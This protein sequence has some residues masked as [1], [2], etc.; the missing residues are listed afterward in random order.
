MS[1]ADTGEVTFTISAVDNASDTIQEVQSGL[2]DLTDAANSAGPAMSDVASSTGDATASMGGLN[3]STMWSMQGFMGLSSTVRLGIRDFEQMELMHIRIETASLAVTKA[4]E[5]Y[6]AAVQKYGENSQQAVDAQQKLTDATDRLNYYQ[7]RNMLNYV[8]MGLQIPMIIASITQMCAGLGGLGAALGGAG[9]AVA[10]VVAALGPVGIA[11]IAIVAAIAILYEAWTND[12]G[13]IRE[14]TASAIKDIQAGLDEAGKILGGMA[15]AVKDAIGGAIDWLKANWPDALVAALTG[16][17]GIAY[18]AWKNNWGGFRDIVSN[19]MKDASDAINSAGNWI[20]GGMDTIGSIVGGAWNTVVNTLTKGS[21]VSGDAVQQFA[22]TTKDAAAQ[23]QSTMSALSQTF[24]TDW[25]GV[26]EATTKA[27]NQIKDNVNTQFPLLGGIIQVA[28]ELIS[29]NWSKAWQDL[30]DL[31]GKCLQ[32]MQK[33]INDIMENIKGAI[34]IFTDAFQA[35]EDLLR[36]IF[37]DITKA[38]TD[39]LTAVEKLFKDFYDWLVGASLWRETWQAVLDITGEAITQLLDL[40]TSKLF[41]PIEKLFSDAVQLVEDIWNKAWNTIKE[42]VDS[43][44][45]LVLA[46]LNTWIN[47]VEKAFTNASSLLESIWQTAWDTIQTVFN[48]ISGAIQADWKTFLNTMQTA[49]TD[50]WTAVEAITSAG[51]SALEAG[52][53]DAMNTI[54]STVNGAI[55]ALEAAWGAF[56][57]WIQAQISLAESMVGG[58]VDTIKGMLAGAQTVGAEASGMAQGIANAVLNPLGTMSKLASATGQAMSSGLNSAFNAIS[59]GATGLFNMLVGH[60]IWTDMLQ[61]MQDQTTDAMNNIVSTFGGAFG[62]IGPAVPVVGFG[63]GNTPAG[64]ASSTVTAQSPASGQQMNITIPIT[65]ALDGNVLT[66]Q[67]ER[68][69]IQRTAMTIKKV[70]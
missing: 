23:T 4:Q 53:T 18:E 20:K 36:T 7:Q 16:P 11:I 25:N 58:A 24:A 59:S 63:A 8:Q 44:T 10:G 5:A 26:V 61:E 13:G 65:V 62:A 52:F 12:W 17:V 51:F 41:E 34:K 15:D 6:N 35:A 42:I 33:D 64:P 40:L 30:A 67:V 22:L 55:A 3:E 68:R 50:F 47:L 9:D 2:A 27:W 48:T 45:T 31:P 54:E 29:G 14:I 49:V 38:V 43:A 1:G 46:D 21:Q 32:Q 19:A 60:S 66:K 69:I 28:M 37:S 57:G 70:A 56:M 39:F